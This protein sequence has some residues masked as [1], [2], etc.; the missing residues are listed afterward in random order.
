MPCWVH[1]LERRWQEEE[2]R[3]RFFVAPD[4]ASLVVTAETGAPPQV[5]WEFLTTPGQ[6]RTW[7]I[8]VTD[9]LVSGT[10]GGRRGPGA[11]NHC[12]H[13]KD[14]VIE[15]ILDWRPYDY[16]TDRTIFHSDGVRVKILHTIELEP[17][18]TGTT[19]HFRFGNAR[20]K[21]EQAAL[22]AFVPG[23]GAGFRSTMGTLLG[24]LEAA[25]AAAD[26]GEGLEPALPTPQPD[27]PLSGLQPLVIVD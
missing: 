22:D 3:Q 20:T 15:E 8:G 19:V 2:D 25:R 21:R 1:D 14:A 23:Y 27:G 16:V 17:T 24:H 18:A 7:Q 9:V 6:R 11:T 26:Q 10:T 12:M 13:G 4:E 5:V